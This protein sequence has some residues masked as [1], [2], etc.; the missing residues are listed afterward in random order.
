MAGNFTNCLP[1][2]ASNHDPPQSQPPQVARIIGM[3][4]WDL[5]SKIFVSGLLDIIVSRGAWDIA[6]GYELSMGMD[7]SSITST[8]KKGGT[9][10]FYSLFPGPVYS[11]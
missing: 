9:I 5:V 11:D 10:Y 6:H 3:S 4:H 2:L 1:R 7:L 8:K